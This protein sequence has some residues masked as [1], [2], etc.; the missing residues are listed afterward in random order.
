M[1]RNERVADD[2]KHEQERQSIKQRD[3]NFPRE[4]LPQ[5]IIHR[6]RAGVNFPLGREHMHA[7]LAVLI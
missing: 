7:A 3:E 1:A 5:K 6:K 4:V 2:F